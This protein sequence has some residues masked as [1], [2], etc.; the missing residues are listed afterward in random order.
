MDKKNEIFS[1]MNIRQTIPIYSV[2]IALL[3]IFSSTCT[4]TKLTPSQ[5]TATASSEYDTTTHIAAKTVDRS[6]VSSNGLYHDSSHP[7]M[8]ISAID[9]N[10][11]ATR[12]ITFGFDNT[13]NMQVLKLWNG[14]QIGV[15][16][17]AMR[18]VTIDYS[19]NGI[20]WKTLYTDYELAKA[21]GLSTYAGESIALN[22]VAAKF[23][24]LTAHAITTDSDSGSWGH[25]T[26]IALSEVE[27]DALALTTNYATN[28][29]PAEYSQAINLN[30]TLA[31]QSGGM[32]LSHDV[33]L[34]ANFNDVNEGQRIQGDIDGNGRTDIIDLFLLSEQWL[35]ASPELASLYADLDRD[36]D[37]NFS[38][39]AL[40]SKNWNKYAQ[41]EFKGNVSLS[42]FDVTG[43]QPKTTYYWRIDEI[44]GHNT[45]KGEVWSFTTPE[46]LYAFCGTGDHL[47]VAE[48]EPVDS[49]NTIDAMFEWMAD[50][51]NINRMYWRGGQEKTWSDSMRFGEETQ[52][53]YDF[54]KW[55]GHVYDDLN[56]NA[57]AVAAAKRHGMEIFLYT[58]LF[59]YGVQPDVGIISPYLFEDTLRIAHPEWC[60]LDRWLERRCPGPISFCYPEVRTAI[61]NR[62]MDNMISYNYDG[63]NF[64]TYVE[65]R[66]IR[67]EDEFGFNQ[68]IVDEF[69]LT[70]PDVNLRTD[71]LT[72][73]QKEYWYKCQGK[74][75][76]DFLTELH[77]EL[78]AY[79]KTLS[80][81][82]DAVE[83][84]YPQ[85][86]WGQ[87]IRGTGKIYMDWEKWIDDG[88]VDEIWVQLAGTADQKALLDRL[89]IKCAG[90][91]IKLTVRTADPLGSTWDSY[92][93]QGVTP[94]AV[95]TWENNNGIEK[96]SLEPTSAGT[97]TSSD[98]KLRLQTL[99]DIANGTLSVNA[100]DVVPLVNDPNVLVRR[101][102]VKA[103]AAL[104]NTSFVSAI[105]GAL[106]DSES[107]VRMAA[108]ASLAS[109]SGSNTISNIFSALEQDEYFQFKNACI[110]TLGVI[111]SVSD[112]TGRMNSSSQAIREVCVRTLLYIGSADINNVNLIYTP[113][114]N[115]MNNPNET[116]EV[117]YWA[118]S[119][120][121]GFRGYLTTTQQ[122]EQVSDLI[123]IVD[124]NVPPVVQLEAASAL[125]NVS[126][127]S[128]Q[129][130]NALTTLKKRF[131]EYGGGST[132]TDAAYGWRVIGN[133]L[134]GAGLGADGE[135]ILRSFLN[136]YVYPQSSYLI[137]TANHY[138]N[139]NYSP[140]LCVNAAGLNSSGL[141]HKNNLSVNA[142]LANSG[143]GSA[144][145]GTV[146]G[147]T[148]IAIDLGYV[149]KL[150][151]L[152]V[153]NIGN[154]GN[155]G[156]GIRNVT[157][158]YSKNGGV[159]P[160]DWETAWTGAFNQSL[161]I[162]NY[163]HET[164]VDLGYIEAHY[165]VITS[166][167]TNGSWGQEPRG[168][169]EVR[170]N[171]AHDQWL[172]WLAYEV[173]YK[174]QEQTLLNGGFNLI[175]EST[176]IMNHDI[177][178]PTFPGYRS[179]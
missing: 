49:S 35:S 86:S 153:W 159:T 90:K 178:A 110:D 94:V 171:L 38:D 20:V 47:W 133:A 33:Y 51:Y 5:V 69:N 79:N 97:L 31:W 41:P 9:A 50:T 129:K 15:T 14:N 144:H 107:S 72:Q 174:I 85:P 154:T 122:Q 40:L 93:A 175:D 43:L 1:K 139:A 75:V 103:L 61:I 27:F 136:G 21:P 8:W 121:R 26:Q 111:A 176:D 68:P 71:V 113:L 117:R 83:P 102:A 161:G 70:Y 167:A 118:I 135:N 63:I 17:R 158:Q 147:A 163:A 140:Q 28:P 64:Y 157:I 143:S 84:N 137:A 45:W 101:M 82:L 130:I 164:E 91:P 125:T 149:Y 123:A 116:K 60:P 88:I 179:W 124:S 23:V 34:G 134:R 120:L 155:T 119:V 126:M 65:N 42:S 95:I 99:T 16:D 59:E 30:I 44:N 172:A 106:S 22:N 29:N 104:G 138:V 76:T 170:I 87:T 165:I 105:E 92:V 141:L 156:Q 39:F 24:R 112:I 108:A 12:S 73:A 32:A 36:G 3:L 57:A 78:A 100:A 7:N 18:H 6:G 89:L 98:W 54:T 81:I 168:L 74:F 66:G 37:I 148:W 166:N 162:D 173:L 58:G 25:A 177:Y 2:S 77:N 151:S 55:S 56:I 46:G 62:L 52:Q 19:T 127:T 96:Y 109:L 4:A 80:V 11:A 53:C 115:V 146:A 132:R 160:S 169:A 142:W 145:P 114:R 10:P 128:A 48:K 13:Y 67:Y 150:D 152:W 131:E